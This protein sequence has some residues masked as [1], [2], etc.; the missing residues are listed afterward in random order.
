MRIR[1]GLIIL[2]EIQTKKHVLIV[3]LSFILVFSLSS[4]YH[5]EGLKPVSSMADESSAANESSGNNGES[6]APDETNDI[7]TVSEDESSNEETSEETSTELP[8]SYELEGFY[9]TGFDTS[10]ISGLVA[11]LKSVMDSAGVNVGIYYEDLETGYSVSYN[12]DKKFCSGSVMKAP[13]AFFLMW[14]G[15]DLQEK[16]TLKSSQKEAGSGVLKDKDSG[17]TYTI[18]KLIEYSITESD[19]TAYRMLYENFGFDYFD[20][21]TA[22]MGIVTGCSNSSLVESLGFLTAREAGLMFRDIYN[23]SKTSED[24]ARLIG[25]LSKTDYSNLLEEGIKN[26][27]VAHK[28]GSMSGAYKVLHDVGIVLADKPYVISIMTDFNPSGG[29]GRSTF[30]SLA[31]TINS[32]HDNLGN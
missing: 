1:K 25:Y 23:K 9:I 19:N 32:F 14:S 20:Y 17:T 13:Y 24:V 11:N 28:F 26:H 16:L 30:K 29:N 22:E 10:E 15:E 8:V 4:C 5:L 27:T 2:M 3:F 31:S 18:E 7:T 12:K 21:Y 6:S